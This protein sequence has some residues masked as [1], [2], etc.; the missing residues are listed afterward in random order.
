MFEITDAT[1]GYGKTRIIRNVSM[2]VKTGEVVALLG[3]NGVGKTTLLKYIMGLIDVFGGQVSLDGAPLPASTARRARAGLGY[4]PQGRYVF[5]R[6]TVTENIAAAAIGC[7]LGRK[8]AVERALANFPI[9]RD[10]AEALAGSLSGGQQ[11]ILAIARA[12]A[13]RPRVLMLDEPSEGVQ[14]SIVDEIAGILMAMKDEATLSI[15]I[16]EQNLDFCLSLAERAYVMAGGTIAREVTR[17]EL[18]GDR[19]LLHDLLGV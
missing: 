18:I 5:P 1:G 6:L 11:Q 4:V 12:L 19:E 3:R 10:K 2:S 8:E 14:P 7:G 16:A 9:L 13:T 15:I 17:D